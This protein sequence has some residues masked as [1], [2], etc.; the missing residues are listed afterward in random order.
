MFKPVEDKVC[1]MIGE[2]ADHSGRPDMEDTLHD[3]GYDSSQVD[4]LV[5]YLEETFPIRMPEG[6]I[7]PSATVGMVCEKVEELVTC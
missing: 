5:M 2:T 6:A 7:K 3:L 1:A 4:V